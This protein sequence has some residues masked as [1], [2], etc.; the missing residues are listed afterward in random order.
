M[1]LATHIVVGAAASRLFATHPAEAFV[2]GLASHYVL[3]SIVHWDYPI[4]AYSSRLDAPGETKVSVGRGMLFDMAKVLL[5]VAIGFVIVLL[6]H[7]QLVQGNLLFLLL[8]A[9]GAVLPDFIQFAYG[10]Y[11][12]PPFGLM[13]RFHHFMHATRN[14]N[15]R[16]VIGVATQICLIVVA[17]MF[18]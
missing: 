6:V 14:F 16:P 7:Q 3:D 1:T 9:V 17:S 8:A 18:F 4:R 12:F 5:D 13:Q 2:I 15:D 10:V 11:K